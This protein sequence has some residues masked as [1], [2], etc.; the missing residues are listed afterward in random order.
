MQITPYEITTLINVLELYRKR[1]FHLNF[2]SVPDT[3]RGE[4][5]GLLVVP[6]RN[7]LL[8]AHSLR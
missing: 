5:S 2:S 6:R 8:T 7:T 3:H 1:K 4:N